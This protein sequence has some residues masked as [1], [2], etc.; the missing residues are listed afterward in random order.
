VND[1]FDVV[2]DYLT[3]LQDRICAAIESIITKHWSGR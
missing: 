3:A 2:R 1:R